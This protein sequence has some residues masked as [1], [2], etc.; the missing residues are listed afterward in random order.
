MFYKIAATCAVSMIAMI[1]AASAQTSGAN[2]GGLY[3]GVHAGYQW[4]HVVNSC[5]GG[6]P[7]HSVDSPYGGVQIGYNFDRSGSFVWGLW[8]TLPVVSTKSNL[9]VAGNNFPAE[10]Q[11]AAA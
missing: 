2:W 7:S 6:C 3:Y 4:G 8:A 9:I 1:S 5:P 10:L 11:W